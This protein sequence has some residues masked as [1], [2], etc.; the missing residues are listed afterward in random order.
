MIYILLPAY[1]EEK[2]LKRIFKKIEKN[3]RDKRK[4]RVVLIDDC[5]TDGTKKIVIKKNN[6]KIIY[7]KHNKNKGLNITME[8]GLKLIDKKSN[9][10]DI[11][12]SL[13]S[14][15]THPISLIPKMIKKINQGNDI[16]IASRF[17]KGSKV[18]GLSSW[19]QIMSHG[20]KLIFKMFYPFKNLNDYT[21]NFRAYKSQHVKKVLN[22]KNFFKNEDFNIA[23]KILL[24]LI[25]NNKNFKIAEVPFTLRYDLKIGNSKMNILK[26][27]F[28]T[29]RLIF[30]RK[31][32]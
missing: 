13:D 5:S 18:S 27:I 12:V 8:T 24:Y 17:V 30:V 4:I 15:N 32:Y 11:I 14:D 10:N 19:R 7:K 2:N 6:F 26:T 21:C 20:A 22:N 23:A 1:N 31:L 9:L 25:T 28:L 29:L 3:F 16:V